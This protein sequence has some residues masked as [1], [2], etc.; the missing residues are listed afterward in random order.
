MSR[1]P[2]KK[3]SDYDARVFI[4]CPFDDAYLPIFQAILFTIHDLGFI[5]RHALI[6]NAKANRL[7]RIAEEIAASRYSIHD[8]SRVTSATSNPLPA[9]ICL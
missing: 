2:V 3:P 5:A 4:N 8:I 9:S 1:L 7:E 6:D